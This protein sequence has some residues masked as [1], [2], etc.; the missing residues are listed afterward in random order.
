MKQALIPFSIGTQFAAHNDELYTWDPDSSVIRRYRQDGTLI[1]LISPAI[2]ADRVR[3][4]DAR[5]ARRHAR[6]IARRRFAPLRNRNIPQ[7]LRQTIRDQIAAA[8]EV[9]IPTTFPVFERI[10]VDPHGYLWAARFRRPDRLD[11]NV[12]WVFDGDGRGVGAA[13][14][15]DALSV[16]EIGGDYLIGV[17]RDLVAGENVEVFNIRRTADPSRDR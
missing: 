11:P 4:R 17:R 2:R 16:L 14:L 3:P 15:P 1:D 5:L 6:E 12:W 10:L 9:P 13:R 8:D 7:S